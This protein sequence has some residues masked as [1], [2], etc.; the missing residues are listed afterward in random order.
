MS[1][2]IPITYSAFMRQV[3]T[4]GLN[5]NYITHKAFNRTRPATNN[6]ITIHTIKNKQ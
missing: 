4:H 2:F 5:T 3:I 1:R 6:N